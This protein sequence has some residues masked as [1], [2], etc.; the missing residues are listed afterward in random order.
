MIKKYGLMVTLLD[1]LQDMERLSRFMRRPGWV[2]NKDGWQRARQFWRL[3]VSQKEISPVFDNIFKDPKND[4]IHVCYSSLTTIDSLQ[5]S[6]GLAPGWKVSFVE[7]NFKECGHT[8][9]VALHVFIS[10]SRAYI[11]V[12]CT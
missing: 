3:P 2:P 10:S 9:K 5:L 12:G 4:T 6:K 11:F 1:E 8:F 7:R